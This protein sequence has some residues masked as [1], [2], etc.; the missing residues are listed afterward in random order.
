MLVAPINSKVG[1]FGSVGMPTKGMGELDLS[2]NP[3]GGLRGDD[4]GVP[5]GGAVAG[6][7]FGISS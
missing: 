2:G 4:D 3:G 6:L 1:P 7:A 5:P